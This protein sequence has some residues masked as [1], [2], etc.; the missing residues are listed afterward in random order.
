MCCHHARHLLGVEEGGGGQTI[1]FIKRS[2]GFY[3]C[4]TI[5]SGSHLR[6]VGGPAGTK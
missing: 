4:C 6:L 2:L 3:H 1:L 5:I